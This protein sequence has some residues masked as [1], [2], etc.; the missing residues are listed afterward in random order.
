MN[1]WANDVVHGGLIQLDWHQWTEIYTKCLFYTIP[2]LLAWVRHNLLKCGQKNVNNKL[3]HFQNIVNLQLKRTFAKGWVNTN[4]MCRKC[5][6]SGLECIRVQAKRAK[7]NACLPQWTIWLCSS[8]QMETDD[9]WN[10]TDKCTHI[11]TYMH[12]ISHR[13]TR[14]RHSAEDKHD[15]MKSNTLFHSSGLVGLVWNGLLLASFTLHASANWPWS[16]Y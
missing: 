8:H 7:Q 12:I 4:C 3:C 14:D 16:G 15:K 13:K 9:W 11:R 2:C 1:I 6:L 10:A 5:I